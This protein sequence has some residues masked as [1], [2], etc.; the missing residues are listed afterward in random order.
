MA[1][2]AKFIKPGAFPS[3]ACACGFMYCQDDFGAIHVALRLVF[4]NERVT[5]G[6]FAADQFA[7]PAH[8]IAQ[9]FGSF[10]VNGLAA[11]IVRIVYC[12]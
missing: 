11:E 6:Y 12:D 5:V 10:P 9:S 1:D 7:R 8:F 2:K 4:E 3:V